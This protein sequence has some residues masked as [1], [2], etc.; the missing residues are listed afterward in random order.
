MNRIERAEI[1]W[2]YEGFSI[3]LSISNAA[4]FPSNMAIATPKNNGKPEKSKYFKLK[5]L[6][7]TKLNYK[8]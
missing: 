2:K 3:E 1:K 8:K 4:Q 7:D 5:S 6:N